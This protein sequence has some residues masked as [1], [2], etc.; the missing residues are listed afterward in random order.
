[1]ATLRHRW[2]TAEEQLGADVPELLLLA[3]HTVEPLVPAVGLALITRGA[4]RRVSARSYVLAPQALAEVARSPAPPRDVVMLADFEGVFGADPG[5]ER[6]ERD[7]AQLI[8]GI[9]GVAGREVQMWMCLLPPPRYLDAAD[10]FAGGRLARWYHANSEILAVAAASARVG[11]VDLPA[12]LLDHDRG[13]F[14]D[15]LWFFALQPYAPG[16]LEALAE[17]IARRVAAVTHVPYKA[18]ALDCDGVLWGGVLGEDGPEGIKVGDTDPVGRAFQATQR[19]LL[20]LVRRGVL[21]ALCSKND[22]ADVWAIIDGHSGMLLRREH[23]SAAEIGW[24]PKSESISAIAQHLGI[25]PEAVVFLDDNPAE[26]AEVSARLPECCSV[27]APQDPVTLAR[28]I[29]SQD[30]FDAGPA[31][32]EDR[33]RTYMMLDERARRERSAELSPEDYLADLGLHVEVAAVDEGNIGR[34]VQLLN[35]TNQFNLSVH[36]YDEAALRD[37]LQREGWFGVTLTVSDRFGDYGL[38][39]LAIAGPEDRALRVDSFLMSCRVLGRNIE[40][41]LLSVVAERAEELGLEAIRLD[42]VV[43]DR[44]QPAHEFLARRRWPAHEAGVHEIGLVGAVRWPRHVAVERIET[45]V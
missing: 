5:D 18:L 36:R 26:V 23:F 7:L 29:V 35:K 11:V 24:Q 38:T 13:A 37:T 20:R 25:L 43:T 42:V 44:N 32:R 45:A 39:G 27:L 31:T 17:A 10:T 28:F 12:V 30:W 19:A 33:R 34:V 41:V 9:R 1:V 21:L 4:P 3:T 16:V 2:K 22:A 8:D 6:F 40:D 14:D 15:R